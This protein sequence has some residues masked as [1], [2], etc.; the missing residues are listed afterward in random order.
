MLLF[1]ITHRATEAW[2]V[3]NATDP[4]DDSDRE[5]DEHVR[6][7]YSASISHYLR[8][9]PCGVF[10]RSLRVTDTIPV[11]LDRRLRVLAR[12]RGKE[13]TPEPEPQGQPPRPPQPPP[14]GSGQGEPST[15]RLQQ[16]QSWQ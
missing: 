4:L 13:P 12:L 2:H 14:G 10:H 16:V 11:S 5:E 1:P 9:S 6:L 7:D 3:V 8:V 15:G